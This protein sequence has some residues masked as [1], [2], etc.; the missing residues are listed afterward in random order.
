[1]K[2]SKIIEQIT[3]EFDN[4]KD[5]TFKKIKSF[6]GK[7]KNETILFLIKKGI[8][9]KNRLYNYAFSREYYH[10][11]KKDKFKSPII[12]CDYSKVKFVNESVKNDLTKIYK[13]INVFKFFQAKNKDLNDIL[14][15]DQNFFHDN[16]RRKKLIKDLVKNKYW[17]DFACGYGGMLFKLNKVCKRCVGIEVMSSAIEILKR[18]NFE[19][20]SNIDQIKN[21][22]VDV[23]TIFQSLE[24]LND[25]MKYLKLFHKKLKKRGK[26]IIET[27]NANKALRELYNNVGYKKFTTLYRRVI[28]SETAIKCLL[29]QVG[30]NNI[31]VKHQQRYRLSNHLGW[32]V[33][34]CTGKEISM[35]DDYKL[36][37]IYSDILVTNKLSDTLFI[38]C[39]KK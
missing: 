12:C 7:V 15:R 18:K 25:H 1:M 9:K 30:F 33:Y 24:L 5:D 36:N 19:I 22:S 4:K 23:I 27:S 16:N 37:K 2:E 32:L 14:Y 28:Y 11:Y 8:V 6:Q 38:I 35:F 20:Y 10:G 17:V 39:N 26:L 21:N 3:S 34:N 29:K 31:D 13:N